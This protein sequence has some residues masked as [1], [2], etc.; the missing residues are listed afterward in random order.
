MSIDGGGRRIPR[1]DSGPST[2]IAILQPATDAVVD[3]AFSRY[4][5]S[6]GSE[7]TAPPADAVRRTAFR[8]QRRRTAAASCLAVA[9]TAV[10]VMVALRGPGDVPT[11]ATRIPSGSPSRSTTVGYDY[12]ITGPTTRD[13]FICAEFSEI[14]PGMSR[15]G[16][17]MGSTALNTGA[18]NALPSTRNV[19][20]PP[21]GKSNRKK[22]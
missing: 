12:K 18:Y 16:T 13:P 11:A 20:S 10:S 5:T 2:T 21:A 19:V 7:V 1:Q 3:L 9:A 22:P 4:R 6:T 17:R 14:A 8:R 15:R